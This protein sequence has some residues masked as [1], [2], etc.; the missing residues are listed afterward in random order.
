MQR[1]KRLPRSDE[2][3]PCTNAN[4]MLHPTPR[5]NHLPAPEE[6]HTGL[7]HLGPGGDI[8]RSLSPPC[9]ACL[10]FPLER[11]RWVRE[12]RL[13]SGSATLCGV[14]IDYTCHRR[15]AGAVYSDSWQH[16]ARWITAPARLSPAT[17]SLGS[18]EGCLGGETCFSSSLCHR[19][20]FYFTSTHHSCVRSWGR[21]SGILWHSR[22]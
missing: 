10:L 18:A 8:K 4:M 7:L 1:Q 16:R 17:S 3:H 11:Q 14:H 22:Q 19:C 20:S 12:W 6:A 21:L 15:L 13:A 9:P 5:I 2:K